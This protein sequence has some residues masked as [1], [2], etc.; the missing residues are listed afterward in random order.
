MKKSLTYEEV[1][2]WVMSNPFGD[3][4]MSPIAIKYRYMISYMDAANS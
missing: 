2:D 3:R 4:T 1:R